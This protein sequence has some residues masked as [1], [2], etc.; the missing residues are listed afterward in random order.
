MCLIRIV[1]LK[2]TSNLYIWGLFF[3]V[4]SS[5]FYSANILQDKRTTLNQMYVSELLTHMVTQKC[6]VSSAKMNIW[7][8]NSF[9]TNVA[10]SNVWPNWIH[11][12][13]KLVYVN[14]SF[15]P[16]GNPQDTS[17]SRW[18]VNRCKTVDISYYGMQMHP[19]W[20]AGALE[21]IHLPLH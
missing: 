8:G 15:Y 14:G 3:L 20:K 10:N 2:C 16:T 9:I 12:L 17:C 5:D 4:A 21:S 6:A 13:N 7:K 18:K 1:A 11:W 19:I